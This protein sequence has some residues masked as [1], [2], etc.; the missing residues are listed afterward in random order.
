ML[1]QKQVI[2]TADV[3]IPLLVEAKAAGKTTLEATDTRD[4]KYIRFY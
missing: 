2:A 3:T 4:G 1:S